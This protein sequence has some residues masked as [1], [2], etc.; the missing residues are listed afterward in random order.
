[1][2]K[3]AAAM[4]PKTV[5]GVTAKEEAAAP[6]LVVLVELP[7][8]AVALP[9]PDDDP[10][11]VAVLTGWVVVAGAAVVFCVQVKYQPCKQQS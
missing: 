1:M 8:D 5:R 10:R 4:L 9:V 6:V 11:R 2:P 3:K 7:E